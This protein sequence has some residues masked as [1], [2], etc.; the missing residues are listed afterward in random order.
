MNSRKLNKQNLIKKEKMDA[1]INYEIL[2]L[3]L[4]DYER[5]SDLSETTSNDTDEEEENFMVFEDQ[6]YAF[7]PNI[8][9]LLQE[10]EMF[11]L[12][13]NLSF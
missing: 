10:D 3:E 8:L 2:N 7:I 12:S 5:G 4:S 9:F 6:D 1:D 13:Y 11:M